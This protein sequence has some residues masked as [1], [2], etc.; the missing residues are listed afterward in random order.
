MICDGDTF[1]RGGLR[2]RFRTKN[3]EHHDVPWDTEDGH[4]IVRKAKRDGSTGFIVKKPG[5]RVLYK[6]GRNEYSFIY[7][8]AGACRM[9]K[10]DGWNAEPYD[11]PNRI[12]RAV[13][14][15]FDRMQAYLKDDWWYVGVIV[16]ML[17]VNGDVIEKESLWGIES[18]S[19]DYFEEV[20]NE[21]A[22]ELLY[23][24]QQAW[25]KA[26]NQR[27]EHRGVERLAAVMA[28]PLLGAVL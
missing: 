18:D 15:D 2:F 24:R 14:A 10:K 3:D 27:R 20:A 28:A 1:T 26:L 6:G 11:A 23:P 4:G 9:A 16:E 12:E 17:D 8:W 22:D 13:Q 21:L 5:D 25:R 7:D 19:G